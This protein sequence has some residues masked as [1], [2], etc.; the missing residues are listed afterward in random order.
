MIGWKAPYEEN[1][2]IEPGDNQNN[3]VHPIDGEVHSASE[4]EIDDVQSILKQRANIQIMKRMKGFNF[5][6][7]IRR[8][9]VQ[10]RIWL[11]TNKRLNVTQG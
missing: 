6:W 1:D 2:E 7:M 9:Q 5:V 8:K 11:L 4:E 10:R 3:I